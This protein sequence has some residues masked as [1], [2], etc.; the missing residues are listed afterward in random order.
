MKIVFMGTPA[1][2]VTI[3]KRIHESYNELVGVVTVM[4]KPAGR[5]LKIN[6]SPVKEFVKKN[7]IPYLQPLKLRDPDFLKQLYAWDADIFIVVAFRMLPEQVWKIPPMGTINL[8][9]SL[10]PNYRGAAPINWALINGEKETG[11]TTFLINE[12]IDTGDIL[13]QEKVSI[14]PNMNAGE[15]HDILMDIGADLTLKT[16]KL[17]EKNQ[18]NA[19]EQEKLNNAHRKEAPK[20]F[21]EHCEINWKKENI[22]IH[23]FIRGLSPYPTAWCVLINK[24]INKSI[25]FKIFDSKPIVENHQKITSTNQGIIFPC[26]TGSILVTELQAEGKRKMNFKEFLAGNNLDDYEV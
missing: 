13:L 2:A 25:K 4:D 3:L 16:I 6:E 9:A 23:N 26:N 8:H 11:V 24:K 22:Q 15:L 17:L 12:K 20:I 14:L 21:K 19:K 1:F 5:G 10:L 18:I 7:N